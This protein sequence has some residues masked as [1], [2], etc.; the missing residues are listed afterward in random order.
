MI[1]KKPYNHLFITSVSFL[2]YSCV[3]YSFSGTPLPR[4]VRSFSIQ[5]LQN[6]AALGPTD[7][8][9]QLSERLS[10]EILQKTSLKQ[11][12]SNGDIQYEGTITEFTYTPMAPK[13]TAQ[14]DTASRTK[15]TISVEL[16]YINKYD[17]E[18]EFSKKNF[19]QSSDMDATANTMAE[20]PRMVEEVLGKLVKDI[21]N[22]SI[23]NW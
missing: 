5:T 19:S 6:K 3:F 11:V 13:A 15:L 7:L 17:K 1:W 23:A 20:E 4:E 2:V 22:G 18:F 16:T 21:F 14:G 10:T 8:N 12:D 9:I